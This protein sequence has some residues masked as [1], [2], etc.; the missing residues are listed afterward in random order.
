MKKKRRSILGMFLVLVGLGLTISGVYLIEQLPTE[1]QFVGSASN[2]SDNSLEVARLIEASESSIGASTITA[3]KQC[4]YLQGVRDEVEI[5]L[6]AV[7]AAYLSFFHETLRT[8]RFIT[9]GDVVNARSSIVVDETIAYALF[10][11]GDAIGKTLNV[12]DKEWTITGVVSGRNRFGESTSGI[13][14]VPITTAINQGLQTDTME[15]HVKS[16]GGTSQAALMRATFE[17]GNLSGDFY[18]LNREKYAAMMPLHWMLVVLALR[19]AFLLFK[20]LYCRTM[21]Q[22]EIY[23]Q[24][25]QVQYSIKLVPWLL[26]RVGMFLLVSSIAFVVLAFAMNQLTAP[27]LVFTDWIPDNLVSIGSY[28]SRFW[29]IHQGNAKAISYMTREMSTISLASWLIRWG[30]FTILGSYLV[31]IRIGRKT[32]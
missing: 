1:Y 31:L 17:Q 7:D 12:Q 3:R 10:S 23:V 32:K 18:D 8:G 20:W 14:F 28:M 5:T 13:A 2:L 15:I 16:A 26:G 6:Y 25:L 21:E 27:A 19:L 9:T 22:Y 11:G 29:T 30:M 24:K 4:L